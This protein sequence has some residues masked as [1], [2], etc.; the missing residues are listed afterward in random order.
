MVRKAPRRPSKPLYG[1]LNLA[2]LDLPTCEVVRALL[3]RALAPL[4][5]EDDLLE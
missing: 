5:V 2:P 4:Q 3:D 1:I